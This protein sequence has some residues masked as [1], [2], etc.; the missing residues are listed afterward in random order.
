MIHIELIS[1]LSDN[2]IYLLHNDK[3]NITSVIDPGEADP[4]TRVL[5]DKN[6][7]LDQIINTHHHNDHTGGNAELKKQWGS[8]LIAPFYERAKK[9]R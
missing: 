6:W 5:K 7:N 8:K 1:A 2:Y 4:V 9:V 3:E